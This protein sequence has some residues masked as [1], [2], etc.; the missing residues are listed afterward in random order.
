MEKKQS[1]EKMMVGAAFAF[2]VL[3]TCYKLTNAP[4]WF[5]ETIEFWYSKI[6][7]GKLPFVGDGLNASTD[8]NM[9]QRILSTYQPPLYNVIMHFWLKIGTSEWWFRF[10]GV[11]M[12]LIGNIGI[13]KAVKRISN[14]YLAAVSVFLARVFF[15]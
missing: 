12:G 15:A 1:I 10:F 14:A 11:V 13:Y 3:I 4:L 7:F 2:F 9:Y 5:D 8:I 6:M